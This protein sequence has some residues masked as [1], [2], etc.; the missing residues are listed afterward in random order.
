MS[1]RAIVTFARSWYT[2]AA[3][4]SLG[5]RGVA[6]IAGDEFPLTPG[7]LSR[8]TSD[9]F[10]Y[11]GHAG[12]AEGFLAALERVVDAHAPD[13]GEP[14]VLMPMHRETYLIAE[15]RDRFADRIA[16]ALP[17]TESI[18]RVRNKARLLSL[19][20]ERGIATPQTWQPSGAAELA[21]LCRQLRYPVFV[22]V[23]AGAAGIGV[24]K[25]D[26]PA[27]LR[28]AYTE[29]V[30]EHQLAPEQRPLIQAA[31][32]GDDYCTTAIFVH[33]RMHCCLTYRN[34]LNFPE[35]GG[36]GAVRQTVIV[37]RL[38][39][40]VRQLL[41]PLDWHGIA[42]VD[43]RWTGDAADEPSLLEV[44]PRFFSGLSHAIESGVDYPWYL[45]ELAATGTISEH[46]VIDENT[47]T[48]TPVLGMLATFKELV[49]PSGDVDHRLEHVRR[50]LEENRDN[51]SALFDADDI[52]PALGLV[53]PLAA[54]LQR[55]S[56]DS[57]VLAGVDVGDDD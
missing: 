48:K 50:V 6:V 30:D 46:P 7:G 25:V 52:M 4:R 42:Q 41:E 51:V 8:Y 40:I 45:Y 2:V 29:L 33:G 21:E 56:L 28:S 31:V 10:R 22:K 27:A 36:P 47:R 43:F 54:L 32:P 53:Y 39:A 23:P 15:H 13:E 14:Y 5:R 9:S 17:P 49:A 55:G 34:E 19:A 16:L 18:E 44:N 11:P 37:P 3:I 57:A 20:R 12:D 26:D 24:E 35:E 1:G 38:Q